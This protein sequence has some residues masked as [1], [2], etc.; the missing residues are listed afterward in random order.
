VAWLPQ[1]IK[2][3][4]NR[5]GYGSAVAPSF[6]PVLEVSSIGFAPVNP[7][8]TPWTQIGVLAAGSIVATWPAVTVPPTPLEE[9][10]WEV[11]FEIEM[12]T[13]SAAHT[14]QFTIR[15]IGGTIIFRH[16]EQFSGMV[17]P[18]GRSFRFAMKSGWTTD[19]RLFQTAMAAGENATGVLNGYPIVS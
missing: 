5:L 18:H 19:M 11:S 14:W 4:L 16:Q 8:P 7:L 17:V 1:T 13:V 10:I 3:V 9:G 2:D 12:T 15:D 6:T